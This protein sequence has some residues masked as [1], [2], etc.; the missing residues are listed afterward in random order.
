VTQDEIIEMA[1]QAKILEKG[2]KWVFD[3]S[4]VFELTTNQKQLAVFAK[5]VAEKER[6]AC[7]TMSDWILKEGGGTWGDA[8]KAR[9]QA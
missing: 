6:E 3:M 1:I 7:A 5:L 2:D 4:N 9:G 8:I